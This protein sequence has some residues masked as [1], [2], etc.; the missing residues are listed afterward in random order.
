MYNSC[1]SNVGAEVN[2][3]A[4]VEI[5]VCKVSPHLSALKG[6]QFACCLH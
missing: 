3:M 2:G 5:E 6:Y 1:A 4:W